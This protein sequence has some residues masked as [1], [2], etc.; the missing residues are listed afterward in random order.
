MSGTAPMVVVVTQAVALDPRGWTCGRDPMVVIT[1]QAEAVEALSDALRFAG[2][3]R[4][5][6]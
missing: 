5:S 4:R 1:S 2:S 3:K 6:S